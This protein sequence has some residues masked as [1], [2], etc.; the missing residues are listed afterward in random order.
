M[1]N[2]N[3]TSENEE[4]ITKR[5]QKIESKIAALWH[6]VDHVNKELNANNFQHVKAI[7]NNLDRAF[8]IISDIEKAKNQRVWHTTWH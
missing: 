4:A 6:L 5:R 8:T 3:L 7:I 1:L 2:Q